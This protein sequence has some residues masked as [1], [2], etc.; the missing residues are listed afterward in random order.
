MKLLGW[1]RER[2]ITPYYPPRSNYR[3]NQSP[4]P[5]NGSTFTALTG[6]QRGWLF[7]VLSFGLVPDI[8]LLKVKPRPPGHK[9]PFPMCVLFLWG[10]RSTVSVEP[11]HEPSAL[12]L[13]CSFLG[14]GL[15]VALILSHIMYEVCVC[16]CQTYWEAR[17]KYWPCIFL[18]DARPLVIGK[19]Y[20]PGHWWCH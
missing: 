11:L 19:Q 14:R 12:K 4:L 16:E 20:E 1:C 13:Y 15:T 9:A 18:M 8:G 17:T 10:W 6:N 7:Y 5:N 3:H 2:K